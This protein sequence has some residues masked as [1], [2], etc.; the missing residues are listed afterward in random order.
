MN[1]H[2]K[3]GML[4]EQ[5]I[6]RALNNHK[7][8][9][10][11]DNWKRHMRRMFPHIK[12]NDHIR[13]YKY[14]YPDAKPDIE[15]VVNDKKIFLSIKSGRSP[16]MHYE[17]IYTFRRF[18]KENGVPERIIK[19]ILFYHYGYSLKKRVSDHILSR[20]E[21]L[22]MFPKEIKE[23]NDYFKSHSSFLV[24]LI[25]RAIIRGRLKR[26]LIDFFYYGNVNK[27]FLLSVTD[28]INLITNSNPNTDQ[29]LAFKCLTYVAVSRDPNN[30]RHHNLKINW[31]ILC[32]Y[33]YD[34]NF[35]DKYG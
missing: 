2:S 28:I 24:E 21:I 22:N 23:A 6:I 26:D 33:F 11:D 17:P 16:C 31:P 10:L 7:F 3:D 35:M 13:T 32:T 18:L 8:I 15:I 14:I 5:I 30:E 34:T 19:I 20:E 1:S 4:N 27:G 29:T 9:D 12:P 25:Y